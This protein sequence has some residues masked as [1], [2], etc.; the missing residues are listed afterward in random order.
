MKCGT[1]RRSPLLVIIG[2]VICSSFDSVS[3][4]I[5]VGGDALL[6]LGGHY[7]NYVVYEFTVSS[8]TIEWFIIEDIGAV[9]ER[10]SR[11]RL[12]Q[13][14]L[15]LLYVAAPIVLCNM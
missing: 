15:L 7:D 9:V 11:G 14:L 12:K 8:L 3:R 6:L 13:S 4:C 10:I 1:D 2:H 5:F